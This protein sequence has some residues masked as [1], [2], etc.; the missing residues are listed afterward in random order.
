[1]TKPSLVYVNNIAAPPEKVWQALTDPEFTQR[2]WYG[3][4]VESDWK[5]GSPITFVKGP[6]MG[7]P[8]TGRVLVA[9]KPRT[10]AFSWHIAWGEMAKEKDSRVTFTIEPDGAGSKLTLVHDEFEEGSAA[11]ESLKNGWPAILAGLKKALESQAP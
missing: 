7:A 11:A 6:G 9:D 5:V 8:D 2:Y 4:R 10:L 1:M 3:T